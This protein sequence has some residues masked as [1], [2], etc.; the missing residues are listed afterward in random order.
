[1]NPYQQHLHR[2]EQNSLKYTGWFALQRTLAYIPPTFFNRHRRGFEG[3]VFN[4]T[5]QS[6]RQDGTEIACSLT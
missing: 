1:M 4:N 3:K 5:P 2:T 6:Y